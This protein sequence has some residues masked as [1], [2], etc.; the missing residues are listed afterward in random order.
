MKTRFAG[1]VF[2]VCLAATAVVAA[3]QGV[4]M[5]I[6]GG[7]LAPDRDDEWDMGAS[8]DLGFIFWASPNVGLWVGGG[9]QEWQVKEET[10]GLSDGG[11]FTIDGR[12]SVVPFGASLLL[13]G[14]VGNNLAV[15]AEGGLRYAAV[16]SDVTV[17]TWQPYSPGYMAVYEDPIEI[18]DTVL[19]VVSLQLEYAAERW[20]LGLGG[21]YQWDLQEPDQTLLGQTVAETSFSAALF[22]ITFDVAF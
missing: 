4:S 22:F 2:G 21:G 14:D 5:A 17:E 13:W 10:L 11:W 15:R 12:T 19:A 9:A 16:E 20:S 3:G 18:D 6:R 1:A 7:G 8:F